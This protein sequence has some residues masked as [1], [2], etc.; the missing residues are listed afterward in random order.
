MKGGKKYAHSDKRE[1]TD[2]ISEFD[3]K[4]GY[5][6]IMKYIMRDDNDDPRAEEDHAKIATYIFI[7]WIKHFGEKYLKAGEKHDS[8]NTH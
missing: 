3:P 1:A 8:T 5:A 6:S 7:M 4:F 2:I